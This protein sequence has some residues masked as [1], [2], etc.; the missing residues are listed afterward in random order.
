MR[1]DKEVKLSTVLPLPQLKSDHLAGKRIGLG[2]RVWW[3]DCPCFT[4]MC[5]YY[6]SRTRIL[7]STEDCLEWMASFP[8]LNLHWVV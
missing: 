7:F 1:F 6:Q 4:K 2:Y 5:F 3:Q 8:I